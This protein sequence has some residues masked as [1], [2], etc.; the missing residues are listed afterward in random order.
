M[1]DQQTALNQASVNSSHSILL[2]SLPILLRVPS[3]LT[4][5][6]PPSFLPLTLSLPFRHPI[7]S[8]LLTSSHLPSH[9][10]THLIPLPS[11]PLPFPFL[12]LPSPLKEDQLAAHARDLEFEI[13]V[14]KQESELRIQ[15]QFLQVR[16]E[17]CVTQQHCTAIECVFKVICLSKIRRQSIVKWIK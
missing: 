12:L 2:S 3:L 7:H 13:L 9:P 16:R 10:S 11:L 4:S 5:L 17:D 1:M 14:R 8:L 6:S 15:R